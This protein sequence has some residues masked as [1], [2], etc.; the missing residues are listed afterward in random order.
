MLGKAEG[1]CAA[2]EGLKRPNAVG[3]F[4]GV[5][6]VGVLENGLV[7]MAVPYFSLNIVKGAVLA[8]AL[9]STYFRKT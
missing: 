3:T 7:V 6:L 8:L 2:H 4:M 1:N 5:V 9:M